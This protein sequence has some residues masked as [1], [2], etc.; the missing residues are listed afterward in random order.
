MPHSA[1][2][3]AGGLLV[4]GGLL[5]ATQPSLPALYTGLGL[6][7]GTGGCCCSIAGVLEVNRRFSGARRGL[8]HGVSL[9]GNTVGGLLLPGLIAVMGD[10]WGH[11]G[12]LLVLAALTL[13][14]LPAA[15]T[16]SRQTGP[17]SRNAD[18]EQSGLTEIS[19]FSFDFRLCV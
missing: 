8:A 17:A 7:L 6:L 14:I 15:M 11:A 5:L 1:V 18:R 16:F 3:G 2:A 13:H 9:A 12:A 4:C 19:A 10:R